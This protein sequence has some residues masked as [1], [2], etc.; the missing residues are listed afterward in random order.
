MTTKKHDD[1]P[2]SVPTSKTMARTDQITAAK[3]DA[4][5]RAVLELKGGQCAELTK[6]FEDAGGDE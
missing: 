4:L 2:K 1:D 6:A 3:L 5:Y